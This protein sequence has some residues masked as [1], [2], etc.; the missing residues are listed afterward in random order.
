M[1]NKLSPINVSGKLCIHQE[2]ISSME[3]GLVCGRAATKNDPNGW[4]CSWHQWQ[5]FGGKRR[6]GNTN[7]Q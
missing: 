2:R 3:Y 4:L 7:A 1:I 5:V 6:E